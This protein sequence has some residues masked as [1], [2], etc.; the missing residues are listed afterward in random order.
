MNLDVLLK[1]KRVAVVGIVLLITIVFHGPVHGAIADYVGTYNGIFQNDSE[2]I[3]VLVVRESGTVIFA[4]ISGDELLL[5]DAGI[6][7]IDENG[8][9]SGS[10]DF[11]NKQMEMTIENAIS[12]SLVKGTY[13]DDD[14]TMRF[15]GVSDENTGDYAGTYSGELGLETTDPIGSWN[16][17]ADRSGYVSGDMGFSGVTLEVEGGVLTFTDFAIIIVY[18]VSGYGL[19]GG[20]FEDEEEY[21]VQGRWNHVDTGEGG[22]AFGNRDSSLPKENTD[23]GSDETTDDD[24]GGG[25]GSG[26]CFIETVIF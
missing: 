22:V 13:T 24:S 1:G 3:W 23:E 14:G 15:E 8:N 21:Q 16:L 19:S 25:G 5:V 11:F 6:L 4:Q 20:Y 26:G 17:T 10:T 7:S 18:N 2:D 12:G 9:V